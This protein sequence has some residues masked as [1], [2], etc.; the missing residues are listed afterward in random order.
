MARWDDLASEGYT[1]ADRLFDMGY[2]RS[3]VNRAYFAAYA[4][5]TGVLLEAG[6]SLPARGNPTHERLP[7]TV[8]HNLV[9][10]SPA[11]RARVAAA[12]GRLY[13]LRIVADYGPHRRVERASA[14]GAL[15]LM[16]QVF[17]EL[18]G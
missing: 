10:L 7:M 6:V 3:C 5:T 17:R 11:A 18:G 14:R 2:W 4:R 16:A 8:Q 1:V 15:G 12:L 9:S 13:R